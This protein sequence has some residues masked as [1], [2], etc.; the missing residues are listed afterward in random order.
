M[1]P[2]EAKIEAVQEWDMPHDVNDVRSFLGFANYYQRYIRQF[3]KVA[4]PLTDLTKRG[5]EWQ[6]ALY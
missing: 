5:V 2:I 1:S 6:C 3:A 4:H